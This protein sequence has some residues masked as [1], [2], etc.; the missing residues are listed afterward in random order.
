M[1]LC[2]GGEQKEGYYRRFHLTYVL[3]EE[4]IFQAEITSSV[5]LFPLQVM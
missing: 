3:K 2:G 4:R 1:A 5:C